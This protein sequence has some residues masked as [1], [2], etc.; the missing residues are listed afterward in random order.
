MDLMTA[1]ATD[2]MVELNFDL[3]RPDALLDLRRIKELK[4]WDVVGGTVQLGAEVS[5][6]RPPALAM[7]GSVAGSVAAGS[8]RMPGRGTTSPAEDAYP[9][10]LATGAVVEAGSFQRGVRHVPLTS[11]SRGS[12]EPD[13]LVSAVVIPTEIA[14]CSF[15]VALD[16]RARTVGTGIGSAGP[17]PLAARAAERFLVGELDWD[18]LTVSEPAAR[19]FAQLIARAAQPVNDIRATAAYRKHSLE[20]LATRALGWIR[21]MA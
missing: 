1:D 19:R 4:D 10:L 7:A 5:Y 14:I 8:P 21:C 20:V 12:L 17:T 15:A 9:V 11:G 6:G 13:E 18:T 3:R 2:V 16:L